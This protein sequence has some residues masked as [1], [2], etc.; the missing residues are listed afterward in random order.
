MRSVAQRVAGM[1]RAGIRVLFDAAQSVEGAIHLEI[2]QPDYPTPAPICE[3]A[4]KAIRE[5]QTRYTPN[6]GIAE[7]RRAIAAQLTAFKGLPVEPGQVVVTTGGMG[8]LATTIE[9]IVDPGSSVLIP[10]PG[11]PNYAMQVACAGGTSI[12]YSLV[13]DRGFVP[14]MQ[15]IASKIRSDTKAIVVNSPSNPTGAVFDTKTVDELASIARSHGL[16]V[17]SD[18]VYEDIVFA[19]RNATFLTPGHRDISVCIYSF[20][21]TYSMTGWRVGYL[22]ADE[23][24]AEQVTKL[25]EVYTACASSISQAAALAALAIDRGQVD[26]MRLTYKRRRDAVLA[27]LWKADIKCSPPSGAFYCLIDI[28]RAGMESMDFALALLKRKRVA[29]APGCTFG[30]N[31]RDMVRISLA[32]NDAALLEGVRRLAE[33]INNPA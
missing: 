8:A 4:I 20:S 24:V 1:S 26:E 30:I 25:Q 7:L 31:S 16:Y 11:W 29:V 12:P 23:Q 32:V 6:A 3:A 2:G 14:D 19:G 33:F 5:G 13:P 28:S 10:D 9:A 21:K 27:E 22:V 18:E 15:D 17:I